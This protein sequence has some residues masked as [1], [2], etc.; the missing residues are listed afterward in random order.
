[1]NTIESISVS[2]LQSGIYFVKL[3]VNGEVQNYK[4]VKK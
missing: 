4:F 3:Q 1:M 2:E